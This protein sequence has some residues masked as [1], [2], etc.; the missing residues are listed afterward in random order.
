MMCS[1]SCRPDFQTRLRFAAALALVLV[2]G[3]CGGDSKPP[4]QPPPSG[5]PPPNA[6]P[7]ANT[8]PAVDSITVQGRRLRQPARFAD[9][10]ETVD[11]TAAVRDPE[12]A[13]EELVYQWTATVGTF[14]GTGRVVTWTAPD[15]ISG[16]TTVTLTLKVV[17]N[18]GHPGQA[19]IFSHDTTSTVTVALHDSAKEVGDISV[20]FLDRFSQ[21]QSIKDWRDVL[22]DF[23]AAAC[24]DPGEY[25]SE[26]EDVERHYK[27][28]HMNSY[29][30]GSASVTSNF[31]GSC[32]VP[33][34]NPLRGDACALVS[35]RWDSTEVT[36]TPP[37][38]AVTTGVDYVSAAYSVTDGRWWLCGSQFISNSTLGHRFYSGR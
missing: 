11:V 8:R 36:A 23:K 24:P 28:F 13:I 25:E 9:V 22:R 37:K 1:G 17:E 29:S 10:R 15:N 19:K 7:P 14:S 12:T 3:A 16:P 33:G 34:R 20:R 31:G 2:V 26:R 35:V 21:P 18:F 30:L 4:T 6:D 27:N 38:T 5:N 32:A